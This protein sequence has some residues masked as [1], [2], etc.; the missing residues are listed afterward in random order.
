MKI[1]ICGASG[2]VGSALA[3][4][5]RNAGHEVVAGGRGLADSATALHVDYAQSV[6]PAAWAAR[7][8]PLRLDAVVNCV[9]ILMA[10]QG[11]TFERLHAQ[12]PV[13]LFRG[14]A[15]AGVA[16]VL[17][18]SALG[19]GG[20]VQL[21]DTPYLRSKRVADDA[22]ATLPVAWAVLRPSMVYGPR[23]QSSQVFATLAKL[24]VISLPGGGDQLMTPVHVSELVQ[25]MVQLLL[26]IEPPNAVFEIGGAQ[27]L[28]YRD[29]LATYR[30]HAGL[31]RAL[32]L[33]V[34]MGLM[35][36][37]AWAAEALPQK[38]LSRDTMLMLERGSVPT[39][40]ALPQLLGRTPSTLAEGLRLG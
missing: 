4:A 30:Q 27:S 10:S 36:L 6:T 8:R 17:Q 1:L 9:G 32:W 5:L 25:A 15:E 3:Q 21:L 22:L 37:G 19:V 18:V 20:D 7:L 11:Q 14:A 16:R 26:Q 12:G 23:S 28:S 31:G 35:K 39:H 13:E 38:M 34:P 33:P 2:C 40:N 29:I 24:P